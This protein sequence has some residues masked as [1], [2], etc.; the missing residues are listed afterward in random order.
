MYQTKLGCA[1]SACPGALAS[2]KWYAFLQGK[3]TIQ[4][5]LDGTLIFSPASAAGTSR[6]TRQIGGIDEQHIQ[7]NNHRCFYEISNARRLG[8]ACIAPV[9]KTTRIHLHRAR[10]EYLLAKHRTSYPLLI[11]LTFESIACRN[12]CRAIQISIP[13]A[14]H[15]QPICAVIPVR[16]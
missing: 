1:P 14:V 13:L 5:S 11:E 10:S 6:Q 9:D 4:H 15:E 12:P 8:I 7:R 16:I 2:A 3:D